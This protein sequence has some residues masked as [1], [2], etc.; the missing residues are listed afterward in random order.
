MARLLL[1]H[2]KMARRVVLL[3]AK[4]VVEVLF[5]DRTFVFCVYPLYAISGNLRTIF[6]VGVVGFFRNWEVRVLED[7]DFPKSLCAF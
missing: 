5:S 4:V 2:Q 1:S 6:E 3:I 7:S